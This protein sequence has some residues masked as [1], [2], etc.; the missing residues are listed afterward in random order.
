MAESVFVEYSGSGPRDV[1][2]DQTRCGRTGDVF[3][4]ETGTHTFDLGLPADYTPAAVT[5]QV[6][7]TT[8]LEPLLLQFD[9]K[10][11]AA[12][13][14]VLAVAPTAAPAKKKKSR[15]KGK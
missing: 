5:K 9:P 13:V 15:K 14:P 10:P 12:A 8:P 6:A 3:N 7:G 2:V 1:F 11:V 4:V